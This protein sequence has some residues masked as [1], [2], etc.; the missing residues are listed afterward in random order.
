MSL[1]IDVSKVESPLAVKSK[2]FHGHSLYG[3][4][5]DVIMKLH[6]KIP[7]TLYMKN[8]FEASIFIFNILVCLQGYF[9]NSTSN[10]CSPCPIATYSETEDADS[11]TPYPEGLTTSL[12]G[13]SNISLCRMRMQ[14]I[15]LFFYKA[16]YLIEPFK[17][18]LSD[19]VNVL[20]F[21]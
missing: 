15:S 6:K 4:A 20:S 3:S 9:L 16:L 18:E 8:F 5:C 7:K 17:H 2:M 12:E 14:L 11:C 21:L 19:L 10:E 13:S 1:Q